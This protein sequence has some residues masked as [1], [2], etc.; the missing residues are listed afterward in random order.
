MRVLASCVL[1]GAA[2]QRESLDHHKIA[3]S[4]LSDTTIEGHFV[5]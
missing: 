5:S 3:V 1:S 2:H 4:V